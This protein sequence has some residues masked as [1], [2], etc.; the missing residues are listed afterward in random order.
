VDG[1]TVFVFLVAAE[2]DDEEDEEAQ[3]AEQAE[4]RD[5]HGDETGLVGGEF[6]VVFGRG[7]VDTNHDSVGI[8]VDSLTR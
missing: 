6:I 7:A 1:R 8:G 5:T 3:Q 2:H 4:D